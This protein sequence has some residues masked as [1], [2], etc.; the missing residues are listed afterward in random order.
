MERKR[1]TVADPG[2]PRPGGGE[3]ILTAKGDHP[4]I[5]P[6]P[7]NCMKMKNLVP[8]GGR[9]VAGASLAFSL[10]SATGCDTCLQRRKT[11][12]LKDQNVLSF[13]FFSPFSVKKTN[14][15][16]KKNKKFILASDNQ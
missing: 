13:I 2:F 5:W 3:G 8:T 10:E 14:P 15:P 11:H 16:P 1:L 9:G 6:F 4:I 12:S 7:E